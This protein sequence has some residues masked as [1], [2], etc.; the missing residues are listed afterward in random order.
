MKW[1]CTTWALMALTLEPSRFG[2][3]KLFEECRV[4]Y[5]WVVVADLIEDQHN[6]IAESQNWV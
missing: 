4:L 5:N 1:K 6:V 3:F 2:F